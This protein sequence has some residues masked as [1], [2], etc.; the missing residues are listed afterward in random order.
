MAMAPEPVQA[1]AWGDCMIAL[2]LI[3]SRMRAR[4]SRAPTA[5]ARARVGCGWDVPQSAT[6]AHAHSHSLWNL[7]SA[8][9][10]VCT[11]L[12]GWPT[13]G[14]TSPYAIPDLRGVKRQHIA[15]LR[16]EQPPLA[17]FHETAAA[18]E[19]MWAGTRTGVP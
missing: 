10:R 3:L 7:A 13:S 16:S 19:R 15:K 11:K 18:Y 6:G 8:C 1:L 9:M 4:V 14:L 12:N 17:A 5:R 2:L